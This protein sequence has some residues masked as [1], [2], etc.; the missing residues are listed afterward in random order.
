MSPKVADAALRVSAQWRPVVLPVL[1]LWVLAAIVTTTLLHP[2]DLR[3]YERYAHAAL[4]PPLLHH[5]PLEYPAPAL[6]VFLLPLVLPVAYP[7]AFALVAGVALV[8]L[9]TSYEGSGVPGWDAH[10]AGRLIIYLALGSVMVVAGRYDIFAA[11]AAFWAVRAAQR[12]RWSTAWTWVSIGFVLKL[13]PAALWPVL[14]IAEWRRLGRVPWRR[15][16]WMGSSVLVLA[17]IPAVLNHGAVL[18][19]LHYYL[20]RPAEIGSIPA[21]LSLLVNFHNTTW[22]SSFH[23]ANVTNAWAGPIATVLELGAITGCVWTWWAQARGRLSMQAACLATLT[24]VV[25][26]SKVLSVQYLIW[27]MPLWALYRLRVSWL[28]ASAANLVV[29]PYAAAATSFGYIPT[30]SFAVSLTLAFLAR[31]LLIA[32]GTWTWL[33]TVY[34]GGD[35]AAA[36]PDQMSAEIDRRPAFTARG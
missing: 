12:D 21:G 24:F 19:A 11:A 2:F 26:G 32:A 7:W 27:L 34:S 35:R 15:L 13:F 14:L 30:H 4:R 20:H 9:A 36:D 25:L 18:N 22:V 1:V 28:L 3:E 29:F 5:L 10:A 6:A 33:R 16:W 8:V 23:S 31:D 17:G